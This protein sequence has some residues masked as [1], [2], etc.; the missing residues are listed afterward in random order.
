MIVYDLTFAIPIDDETKVA[1][2]IY[3]RFGRSFEPRSS[4]YLGGDYFLGRGSP[5]IVVHKNLDGDEVAEVDFAEY[6]VLLQI[7]GCEDRN[8]W[9]SWVQE[10]DGVFVRESEYELRETEG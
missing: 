10:N 5:E 8:V 3:E 2:L 4:D 1:S 7:N 6:G 9:K